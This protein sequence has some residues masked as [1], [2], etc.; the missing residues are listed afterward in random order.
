MIIIILS[1]DYNNGSRLDCWWFTLDRV[2][3]N[4]KPLSR[5][6]IKSY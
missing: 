3:Q 4:S 1:D 6:T 5:I 2:A